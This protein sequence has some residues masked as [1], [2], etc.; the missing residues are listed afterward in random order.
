MGFV[1]G[2][3]EIAVRLVPDLRTTS[4]Q[5]RGRTDGVRGHLNVDGSGELCA[6]AAVAP[7]VELSTARATL[8][9][10]DVGIRLRRWRRARTDNA[11]A[12]MTTSLLDM[13]AVS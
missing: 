5:K 7:A 1:R 13:M 2:D 3:E 4:S 12:M 11:A 10:K 6:H 9:G 8:D